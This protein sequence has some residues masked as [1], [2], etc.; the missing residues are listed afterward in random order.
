MG[1]LLPALN[2]VDRGVAG[3]VGSQHLMNLRQI[4]D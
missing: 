1:A 2:G 4:K 3:W